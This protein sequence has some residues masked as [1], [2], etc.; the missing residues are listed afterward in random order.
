MRRLAAILVCQA[1]LTQAST[2]TSTT[3]LTSHQQPQTTLSVS[4]LQPSKATLKNPKDGQTMVTTKIHDTSLYQFDVEVPSERYF[5]LGFSSIFL[6]G[7]GEVITPLRTS[8]KVLHLFGGIGPFWRLQY[9]LFPAMS[10]F[11]RLDLSAGPFIIGAGGFAGLAGLQ[12]G[13]TWYIS[14]WFGL[15][16]GYSKNFLYGFETLESNSEDVKKETGGKVLRLNLEA[17]AIMVG[18]KTTYF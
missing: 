10:V 12:L 4:K 5:T 2:L 6:A 16:A 18:L 14:K 8:E 11:S 13:G 9:I 1:S 15:T 7:K 17:D 3:E